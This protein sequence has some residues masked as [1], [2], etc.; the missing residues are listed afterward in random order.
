M[1][2]IIINGPIGV[3]KSTLAS[4]LHKKLE[5]QTFLLDVDTLRSHVSHW[6]E[7]KKETSQWIAKNCMQL[8]MS[9][10]DAGYDVIFDKVIAGADHEISA[11]WNSLLYDIDTF[12]QARNIAV[13]EIH[14]V[15]D[16]DVV[17]ARYKERNEMQG[18][19][20]VEER[21]DFFFENIQQF[22]RTRH[23]A[24]TIDVTQ[25]S[26]ENVLECALSIIHKEQEQ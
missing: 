18:I 22:L 21:F 23:H 2:I 19:D 14:L 6:R 16:R 4:S 12:A 26:H 25:L 3:G 7:N 9:A 8:I 11:V 17:F 1:K 20:V 5:R 10:A 13:Q 15:A 24:H